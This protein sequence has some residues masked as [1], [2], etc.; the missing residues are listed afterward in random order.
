MGMSIRIG[1]WMS[2]LMLGLATAAH[3]LG[4]IDG[5][6]LGRVVAAMAFVFGLITVVRLPWDLT[7]QARS[8]LAQMEALRARGL[9]VDETEIRFARKSATRALVLGLVLHLVGAGLAF[10]ARSILGAELGIV[11]AIAFLGSMALRPIHAF[12]LH[13]R[14]RLMRAQRDAAVP[15]ADAHTLAHAD[16]ELRAELEMMSQALETHREVTQRQLALIEERTV[17]EAN[18]W[19]NAATSTD[20]KLERV[21]REFERTVDR[22]QQ[23]GEVLA[24]VRA[25]VQLIRES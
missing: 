5:L 11:I 6:L 24:G 1:G 13:T 15:A 21:L 20:E 8:A 25:F 3:Q 9:V 4:W 17:A 18:A 23:N 16:A 19:R 14:Q 7:F 12:Y 22:T 2:L 10:A